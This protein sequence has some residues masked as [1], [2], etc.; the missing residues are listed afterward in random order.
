[1]ANAE[2]CNRIV[3]ESPVKLSEYLKQTDYAKSTIDTMIKRGLISSFRNSSMQG[4]PVF[5]FENELQHISLIYGTNNIN[6]RLLKYLE[7]S[8]A[9]ISPYI[10][11]RGLDML[12]CHIYGKP[13]Q[14]I[15]ESN[16]LT[17]ER[18]RRIIDKTINRILYKLKY[19]NIEKDLELKKDVLLTEIK[20]LEEKKKSLAGKS[21]EN[22][23]I[24]FNA[25]LDSGI[26]YVGD[27]ISVRLY[28][29]LSAAKIKTFRQVKE[30]GE[31]DLLR[32]RNFGKKSLAELIELFEKHGHKFND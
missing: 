14:D 12:K 7:L 30:I 29:C 18:V 3:S 4:S 27:E 2:L 25:F 8:I 31:K 6:I 10:N 1:L 9:L 11:E 28:N 16:G 20:L 21:K 5:I 13:Y 23:L 24:K 17:T 32:Y 26:D 15:A 19:I 22:K